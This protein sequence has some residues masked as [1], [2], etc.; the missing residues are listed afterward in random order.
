MGDWSYFYGKNDT[1][2][3][4]LRTKIFKRLGLSKTF[5]KVT[6]N[7]MK[8]NVVEKT[9]TTFVQSDLIYGIY[10]PIYICIT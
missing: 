7:T 2:T 8:Q 9:K 3:V 10:D 6:K 1:G 4:Q 5:T